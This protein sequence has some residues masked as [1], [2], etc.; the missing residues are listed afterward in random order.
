VDRGRASTS[1]GGTSVQNSAGI[2]TGGALEIY[3]IILLL[4]ARMRACVYTMLERFK[5]GVRMCTGSRDIYGMYVDERNMY[6]FVCRQTR[7][8]SARATRIC[9]TRV[10]TMLYTRPCNARATRICATRAIHTSM[11]C[12]CYTR[13]V[14]M[15][16][17]AYT[18]LCIGGRFGDTQYARNTQYC[19]AFFLF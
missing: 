14:R 6:T 2:C 5:N 3:M 18:M 16:A 4:C 7:P 1:F 15:Y 12:T 19:R 8:C 17:C 9:A 10:Y 13:V 11:K